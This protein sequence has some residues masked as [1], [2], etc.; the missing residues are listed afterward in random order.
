M[1]GARLQ[2]AERRQKSFRLSYVEV[3]SVIIRVSSMRIRSAFKI[4]VTAY[5]LYQNMRELLGV[6][7]IPF[8]C[9]AELVLCLGAVK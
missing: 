8:L 6:L 4:C 7:P 1:K 2:D 9:L 3:V 5:V